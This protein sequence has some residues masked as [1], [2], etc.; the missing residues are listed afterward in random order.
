M[1]FAFLIGK[2]GWVVLHPTLRAGSAASVPTPTSVIR[3]MQQGALDRL[4]LRQMLI[5]PEL[6]ESVEPD[7]HLIATL[8]SLN[9]VI[10]SKTKETACMVGRAARGGGT[11]MRT[12]RLPLRQAVIG[13]LN[14]A[15]RNRCRATM[16][17]TGRIPS[18]SIAGGLDAADVVLGQDAASL[19][20]VLE[21]VLV[22]QPR[23]QPY[24]A[25][26]DASA[27]RWEELLTFRLRPEQLAAVVGG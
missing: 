10:L 17:W 23:A 12:R 14:R 22:L 11:G 9:H 18:T 7:V 26:D 24:D 27:W 3:V 4:D 19:A 20:T 15:S 2:A 5:E 25:P 16:R 1:T 13:S 8:V 6:L 21:C